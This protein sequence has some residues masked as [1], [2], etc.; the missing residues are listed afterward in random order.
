MNLSK[1]F[2]DSLFTDIN[3][4]TKAMSTDYTPKVSDF[5]KVSLTIKR[6]DGLTVI[7]GMNKVPD[8]YSKLSEQL[9]EAAYSS[10]W[11]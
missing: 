5:Q 11:K 10:E 8:C 4:C 7:T 9:D 6:R 2:I 3:E 1:G